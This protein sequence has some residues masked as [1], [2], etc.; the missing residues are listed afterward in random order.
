MRGVGSRVGLFLLGL[1]LAFLGEARAELQLTASIDRPAIEAGDGAT[2]EISVEGASRVGTTPQIPSVD[3]LEFQSRG[4]STQVS[5]VN[6]KMTQSIHFNYL[7]FALRPGNYSL[8]PVTLNHGGKTYRSNAVDLRV[9]KS[10]PSSGAGG[11]SASGSGAGVAGAAPTGEKAGEADALFVRA[12]VDKERAVLGEQITLRFQFFQRAGIALLDQPQYAPPESPGFWREDLPPQR[13]GTRNV[14]STPYQVTEIVYALFPTQSG[15][16]EIGK[17][18]LTCTVQVP[19][20]RRT[21]DPFGMFGG[22]FGEQRR[23]ALETKPIAIQ[24]DALPEPKPIDFSGGVGDFELSASPDRTEVPQNE[25]VTLTIVVLGSGNAS[26][27]GDPKLAVLS[28]FRSYPATSETEA[29]TDGDVARGKK[30]FKLVLIPET[31]GRHTIPAVQLSIYQ[32]KAKRYARLTAGPWAMQ[33]T[34]G[35]TLAQGGGAGAVARMGRDLRTI[36]SETHLH[37]DRGR[38]GNLSFWLWQLVP[39]AAVLA[40]WFYRRQ[41]DHDR[42]NW[43]GFLSRRAPGKL[44]R[45]LDALRGAGTANPAEGFRVLFEALEQYFSQRFDF[46]VRGRTREELAA[47]LR[48]SA[49]DEETIVRVF[50]LL[51]RCDFAL[52]ASQSLGASDF[53]SVLDEALQI[54]DRLEIAKPVSRRARR[55]AGNGAGAGSAAPLALLLVAGIGSGFFFSLPTPVCGQ[56]AF[57]V[58]PLGDRE[59]LETFQ[60]GNASYR[61]GDYAGAVD[62]YRRV[63]AS[64]YA[65]PDLYLN[66]GNAYYRLGQLGWAVHAFELGGRLAPS[67]PDLRANLELAL[68]ETKDRTPETGGNALLGALVSL[69]DRLPLDIAARWLAASWWIF[70]LWWA[71]RTALRPAGGLFARAGSVCGALLFAC[72]GWY[73]VQALREGTRPDAVVVAEEITVRS[74][75]DPGA[76]VEFSL[77]AG[78]VVRLGRESPGYREVLFSDRLRGWADADGLASLGTP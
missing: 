38:V 33:V 41:R 55:F 77:H 48:D 57:G 45:T 6:G 2:L 46:P 32:P 78:T 71:A 30:T 10:V 27:V 54:A 1:C 21:R 49:V 50:S 53:V 64:G 4:Q 47:R 23:F 11:N 76:T 20:R 15:R 62:A 40:A 42:A 34:P 35:A 28:G 73:G 7:V 44:R 14:G 65:S 17:A 19:S 13:T 26:T 43:S 58:A 24:V 74:N 60:A 37:S 29:T 22:L 25:P 8:G 3:G 70:A 56:V 66:L 5:I 59:A 61:T 68:S 67:D 36:R 72:A 75:P 51:D 69:Q 39:V 12:V 52:F 31:T 16:L 18:S 63:A 9:V